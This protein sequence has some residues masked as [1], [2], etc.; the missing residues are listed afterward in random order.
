MGCTRRFSPSHPM[1]PSGTGGLGSLVSPLRP[2]VA[3]SFRVWKP[4]VHPAGLE[5]ATSSSARAAWSG[6]NRILLPAL[7]IATW[8]APEHLMLHA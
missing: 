6:R 3:A 5:P 2:V 1:T 8:E 4:C 7:T